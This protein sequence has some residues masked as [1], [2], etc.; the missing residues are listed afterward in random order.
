MAGA[1]KPAPAAEPRL[2]MGVLITVGIVFAVVFVVPIAIGF[3][4]LGQHLGVPP[5]N[6]RLAYGVAHIDSCEPS[7]TGFGLY[8]CSATED[9]TVVVPIPKYCGPPDAYAVEATRPLH[10][11]V[12]VS[13]W[14]ATAVKSGSIVRSVEPTDEAQHP[15]RNWWVMAISFTGIAIGTGVAIALTVAVRLGSKALRRRFR[16]RA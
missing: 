16:G 5:L 1:D 13:Y 6:D 3:S 14:C 9:W 12:P 15:E 11:D 8:E 7:A 10:G 4:S 2:H